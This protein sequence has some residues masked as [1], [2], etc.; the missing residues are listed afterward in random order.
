MATPEAYDAIHDKLEFEWTETP[1]IFENDPLRELV[2]QQ[3]FVFVEVVGD[4][5]EQ[6]TFGAP[7]GNEWVEEGAAYLHV[8]V[9]DGTGSREARAIGK[10]LTNLFREAPIGTMHFTRMSIGAGDVGRHF[11][12]FFAMTVTIGWSRRDITG[13]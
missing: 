13:A 11:P 7:G 10:R 5:L 4:M 2:D 8:M 3:Y 6:D 9:P 1:L 12:N